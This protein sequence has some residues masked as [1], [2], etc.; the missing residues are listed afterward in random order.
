MT[1]NSQAFLRDLGAAVAAQLGPDFAYFKSRL[2]LRRKTPEGHDVVILSGSAKYSPYVNVAFYYGKN[3]AAARALEKAADAYA[4]P[5]HIQQFSLNWRPS[6]AKTYQSE[7]NWSIDLNNPPPEF[8]REL[9]SAIQ[10]IAFPFFSRFSSLTVA[11]RALAANDPD[12]FGG[13]MFW[14]QLLRLD[15]VLGELSHFEQ[16]S[17]CLDDWTRKQA[18]AELAKFAGVTAGGA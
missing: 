8:A 14:S 7:G 2:E 12:C 15:A 1:S 5:F 4:F 10:G 17:H 13:P 11:R 6:P 9:V 3:F 18:Q 16:W